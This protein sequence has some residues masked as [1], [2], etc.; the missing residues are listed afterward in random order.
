MELLANSANDTYISVTESLVMDMNGNRVNPV[1]MGV[2]NAEQYVRDATPPNLVSVRIDLEV[3]ELFLTFDEPVKINTTFVERVTLQSQK[4]LTDSG[5]SLT[6]RGGT[7][8]YE[9]NTI[10]KTQVMITILPTDIRLIKLDAQL[11]IENE[12]SAFVSVMRGMIRDMAMNEV[13]PISSNSSL[14]FDLVEYDGVR[15]ILLSFDID[16]DA[17]TLTL[18]FDDVVSTTGTT[19]RAQE[20]TL[21]SSSVLSDSTSYRLTGGTT[22]S[23]SGYVVVVNIT[24]VDLNAIKKNEG[25][26][27]GRNATYL[28]HTSGM[29]TDERGLKVIVR[30]PDDGLQVTELTED[31]TDPQLAFYDMDMDVGIIY[32]S[33]S[34]TVKAS[35]LNRTLLTL[36]SVESTVGYA[37]NGSVGIS[38]TLTGGYH[39]LDDLTTI[40]VTLSKEDRDE[41]K[42]LFG[43]SISV[44]STFLSFPF[45]LIRDMNYNDIVPHSMDSAQMART[46]V[47]DLTRPRLVFWDLDV[48][49]GNLSMLLDETVDASTFVVT[50]LRIQGSANSSDIFTLTGGNSTVQDGTYISVLLTFEDL[51]EV[52]KID[53]IGTSRNDSFLS[54][55]WTLVAD[56]NGNVISEVENGKAQQAR[57]HIPDR[58]APLLWYYDLDVDE[59]MMLLTFSE[60]V[61][62]RTVRYSYFSLQSSSS[63]NSSEAALSLTGGTRSQLNSR[64]LN[65]TFSKQDRDELTR[66]HLLAVSKNSSYL[67]IEQNAIEDMNGNYIQQQLPLLPVV[68]VEDKTEPRLVFVDLDL[69]DGKLILTFD[70]TVNAA[71]FLITDLILQSS[72]NASSS[73]VLQSRRLRDSVSSRRDSVSIEV[74]LYPEDLNEIK[75]SKTLAISLNST[76]VVFTDLLVRDMNRNKVVAVNNR[77]AFAAGN[78][79]EDS[80]SP[81]L[82]S[83]TVNISASQLSLTFSETVNVGSFVSSAFTFLHVSNASRTSQLEKSFT[84]TS[85]T[86]SRSP[87]GVTMTVDISREDL[88]EIKRIR[89]LLVSDNTTFLSVTSAGIKDMNENQVKSIPPESALQVTQFLPDTIRPFLD[90][91]DLDLDEGTLVL[92]FSETVDATSLVIGA[93]TLQHVVSAVVTQDSYTLV[94]GVGLLYSSSSSNDSTVITIE[95]GISDLNSLKRVRS[96]AQSEESTYLV[97]SDLLIR[98]MVGLAVVPRSNLSALQ[99][100]NYTSDVTGP[101]LLEF[102][103]NLTSEYL[104]LT[105][106]ET[107]AGITLN[108]SQLIIQSDANATTWYRLTGFRN[109]TRDDNHVIEIKLALDD[110]HAIKLRR[111]LAISLESSWLRILSGAVE[112]TALTPNLNELATLQSSSFVPDFVKPTVESYTVDMNSGLLTFNFDEPMDPSTLDATSL[113]LQTS[114]LSSYLPRVYRLTGGTSPSGD[115]LQLLLYLSDDDLNEIKRKEELFINSE[116]SYLVVDSDFIKDMSG[117][118]IAKI[119][120]GYA[121][122][123]S[124]YANDTN[125]A[126]LIGVE[127][128]MNS[129]TVTLTFDETMDLSSLQFDQFTLQ[130][131]SNV[132]SDEERVTL[133][134][135]MILTI[136]D[137][138]VFS[139]RLSYFDLNQVKSKQIAD[140]ASR[141]WFVY[142]SRFVHDMNRVSAVAR[143]NGVNAAN[144]SRHV[145]DKTRPRLHDFRISLSNGTLTLQFSEAIDMSAVDVTGLLLQFDNFIDLK[146]TQYYY[147]LTESSSTSSSS[148][149]PDVVTVHFSD[150]DLDA[151]KERTEL[152]ISNETTYISMVSSTFQDTVEN[153]VVAISNRLAMKTSDFEADHVKPQ[154]LSFDLDLTKEELV[155]S[156]SE[157]VDRASLNLT[158]LTISSGRTA[159]EFSGS[160]SGSGSGST[161]D[162]HSYT[163]TGGDTSGSNSRTLVIYLSEIDLNAIKKDYE[164]AVNNKTTFISFYSGLILDLNANRIDGITAADAN[165][166]TNYVKDSV[167][168]SLKSYTLDLNG[169]S[170]SLT[171]DETVNQNTLNVTQISFQDRPSVVNT[172][173]TLTGGVSLSDNETVIDVTLSEDDLNEIKRLT[174]LAT[175]VGNTFV[176]MQG[177]AIRDMAGNPVVER[178]D[179]SALAVSLFTSD[180]TR[181]RLVAYSLDMNLGS[182]VL[183]FRETVDVSSLDLTKISLQSTMS[184]TLMEG[185]QYTLTGGSIVSTRDGTSVAAKLSFEDLNAIKRIPEIASSETST[186]L[187]HDLGVIRD[188]S[189]NEAAA[190]L[191]GSALKVSQ[192]YYDTTSPTLDSFTMEMDSGVML[193]TF[194]E[195]VN[196]TT[197][198]LSKFEFQDCADEPISSSGSDSGSSMETGV[199]PYRLSGGGH[200]DPEERIRFTCVLPDFDLNEIKRLPICTNSRKG[201]DCY[202]TFDGSLI[203]DMAGNEIESVFQGCGFPATLL[204][205][206]LTS[207]KL[208]TFSEFNLNV[209]TISLLFDETLNVSTVNLTELRL[210][211]FIRSA[212]HTFQLTGGL[213]TS[214]DGPMLNITLLKE[215]V[216]EIKVMPYVCS[217]ENNCWLSFTSDFVKDMAMNPAAEVTVSAAV[218]S[219]RFVDDE[220]SPTL[221]DYHLDLD[222]GT[223]TLSFD[224]PV[225]TSSLDARAITIQNRQFV[226]KSFDYV[227]LTGGRS[228]SINGAVI[229]VTLLEK[230]VNAIKARSSLASSPNDTYVRFTGDLISDM[231]RRRPNNVDPQT[232]GEALAAEEDSYTGDVT[233]PKLSSFD[234]DLDD[235][236]LTLS[237]DEPLRISTLNISNFQLLSSNETEA[238][239]RRLTGGIVDEATYSNGT[240]HVL[241]HLYSSDIR[242]L[243]INTSIATERG[244]TR[245]A[246]FPQTIQDMADN[247]ASP[248]GRSSSIQVS[249]FIADQTA[250]TLTRYVLDLN[251][252][253]LRLTFNDV[254]D[255]KSLFGP[256]FTLQTGESRNRNYVSLTSNST[257]ASDSGYDIVLQLSESDLNAVK[258]NVDLGTNREDTYLA[259]TAQAVDDVFGVDVIAVTDHHALRASEVIEDQTSPLLRRFSLDMD[260]GLLDLTFSETIRSD[261]FNSTDIVLVSSSIAENASV[262]R[263][264]TNASTL[265]HSPVLTFILSTADVNELK[266]LNSLAVSKESTFLSHSLQL[267]EDMNGN[268]VDAIRNDAAQQV[269][270]F[271]ADTTSPVLQGFSLNMTSEEMSLTFDETVNGSTLTPE[272]IIMVSPDGSFAYH[273]TGG[274]PVRLSSTVSTLRL[275]TSDLN[276]LKSF[277]AIAVSELTTF[278]LLNKGAIEDMAGND[279]MSLALDSRI[280]AATFYPDTVRPRLLSF[281]LNMNTGQMSLVFDET[282]QPTSTTLRYLVLQTSA[283]GISEGS[284]RLTG[285]LATSQLSTV[286]NVTLSDPDLNILKQVK[287]IA[288]SSSD[289]YL[290]VDAGMIDDV[291]ANPVQAIPTYQAMAVSQYV[292]DTNRPFVSAFVL[293]MNRGVVTMTFSETVLFSSVLPSE[294]TLLG[295]PNADTKNA[296]S[297]VDG[298]V[299][300]SAPIDN[301]LVG[302]NPWVDANDSVTVDVFLTLDDL[303]DL[304]RIESLATNISNTY[305]AIES[306]FALDM[307]GNVVEEISQL[308]PLQASDLIS[309]YTPPRLLSFELDMNASRLTLS[310]S[311]TVDVSYLQITSISL[312]D[313]RNWTVS[314]TFSNVSR[315]ISGDGPD[316]VIDLH[317]RDTNELKRVTG[318]STNGNNT[319]LSIGEDAVRDMSNNS[320]VPIS[321]SNALQVKLFTPDD[322]QP[323][324]ESFS[325]DMDTGQLLLTFSET[326]NSSS[327]V[328]DRLQLQSSEDLDNATQFY[329]LTSVSGTKTT[330]VDGTILQVAISR[331]DS[332]AIKR[333]RQLATLQNN[334]FLSVIMGAVKDMNDLDLVPVLVS[335][336]APVEEYFVDVS[337]PELDAFS[338]NLTSEILVLTFDETVDVVSLDLSKFDLV[339][340]LRPTFFVN[341]TGGDKLSQEDTHVVSVKL[342]SSDLN[343]IKLDMMLATSGENTWLVMEGYAVKDVAFDQNGA[344]ATILQASDFGED[345]VSPRVTSFEVDMNDGTIGLVFNEPVDANSFMYQQLTLQASVSSGVYVTLSGGSSNSANGLRYTVHISRDDLNEVKRLTELFT[346]R[347]SSYISF[348]S[349]LVRDIAGNSVTSVLNQT[350]LQTSAFHND[351]I[352]PRIVNFDLDMNTGHVTLYFLET[353]D[354]S[355]LDFEGVTLQKALNVSRDNERQTLTNG[356]LLNV[357]DSVALRF[358]LTVDDLNEIKRKEIAR[359]NSTCYLVVADGAVIDMNSQPVKP[360]ENGLSSLPVSHYTPD[361]TPPRLQSYSLNLTSRVLSLSFTETVRS[362]AVMTTGL[363]MQSR[364][365]ASLHAQSHV[366]SN[367]SYVQSGDNAV[368]SIRLEFLDFNAIKRFTNLAVSKET[369]YLSIAA[370]SV[371]DMVGNLIAKVGVSRGLPAT[372]FTPDIVRPLLNSYTLDMDAPSL[373]LSFSETVNISSLL[374]LHFTIQQNASGLEMSSYHLTG[375]TILGGNDAVV[376]V[377][378]SS[379]DFN[380]IKKRTSLAVDISSTHLSLTSRS[381][382]D[383]DGNRILEI[384]AVEALRARSYIKDETPPQITAFELDMNEGVITLNFSETVNTTSVRLSLLSIRN[385]DSNATSRHTLTD[386]EVEARGTGMQSTFGPSLKV[387]ISEFDLND[388]KAIENLAVRVNDTFLTANSLFVEDMDDN[389]LVSVTA[390]NALKV[391]V[392]TDDVTSPTLRSFDVNMTT[393]VLILRFSETVNAS[394]LELTEVSLQNAKSASKSTSFYQ[395]T[396]GAISFSDN[397]VIGVVLSDADSN[398]IKSRTTLFTSVNN[399]YVSLSENTIRD[400]RR[401]SVVSISNGS[402]LRV[403]SFAA[404]LIRPTLNDFDLNMT[405]EQL[406][407][408]FSESVA[409]VSLD[410]T[411]ITLQGVGNETEYSLKGG[412]ILNS[413]NGTTVIIQ[414][415]RLDANNIQALIGLGDSTNTTFLSLT[416]TAVLDMNLNLVVAAN[417][418]SVRSYTEDTVRP[419]LNFWDIN[420]NLGTIALFFSETVNTFSLDVGKWDLQSNN[421]ESSV[422]HRFDRSRGTQTTSSN[423]SNVVLEIGTDDLNE[424]KKLPALGTSINNTYISFSELAVLDMNNNRIVPV[425]RGDALQVRKFTADVTRPIL[426]NFVLDMNDGTLSLTFSETINASSFFATSMKLQSVNDSDEISVI[427]SGRQQSL[428]DDYIVNL[429]LSENTLN[430]IKRMS[431][432]ATML[433][434]TFLSLSNE[435]VEDMNGNAIVAIS[436]ENATAAAMYYSDIIAPSLRSFTLDLNEGLLV[437]SFSETVNSSSLSIDELV[438]HNFAVGTA[439]F[440]QYRLTALSKVLPFDESDSHV[441]SLPLSATDLNELKRLS[442]LSSKLDGS[443]TF[444]AFNSGFVIDMNGNEIEASSVS[445]GTKVSMI[446]AD[447][448]CPTLA[449][450]SLDMNYGMIRLTF[451]ETVNSSSLNAGFVRIQGTAA[452]NPAF[453]HVFTSTDTDSPDGTILELSV[454]DEDLNQIKILPIVA[455]S[456]ENSWIYLKQDA[457]TDMSGNGYCNDTRP[458]Q[459]T[460]GNFTADSKAP[461]LDSYSVDMD[462]GLIT[463]TFSEAV[464]RTDVTKLT[465]HGSSIGEGNITLTG[466]LPKVIEVNETAPEVVQF[467]LTEIDLNTLKAAELIATGSNDTYLSFPKSAFSDL[468]GNVMYINA[469]APRAVA[470]YV[471]DS[472]PPLLTSFN[473]DMNE[474]LLIMSFS[475]TVNVTSV[476]VSNIFL[477]NDTS[478]ILPIAA[479][480]LENALVSQPAN[481][482]I[483]FELSQEDV[484]EIKR[485]T[486]L[487]Y[488]DTSTYLY[489]RSSTLRD[490]V[491]LSVSSVD[492]IA[493]AKVAVYEYDKT[494]PRLIS[495]SV[496]LTSETISLSFDETVEGSSLN[497][498]KISLMSGLDDGDKYTLRGGTVITEDSTIVVVQLE[499]RDLN[500]IKLNENLA[501]SLNNT[502]LSVDADYVNDLSSPPQSSEAIVICASEYGEDTVLPRLTTFALDIN[503][504]ILTLNFDEPVRRSSVDFTQLALQAMKSV[505]SSMPNLQ[506]RLAGGFSV[507]TN[508]LILKINITKDDL[509]E[510]KRKSSLATNNANTYIRVGSG[511]LEDMNNNSIIAILESSAVRVSNFVGDTGRPTLVSFDLDMDSSLLT[512]YFDETVDVSSLRV[513]AMDLQS[514]SRVDVMADRVSL[515]GMLNRT[516]DDTIV[517]ILLSLDTM[518]ELKTKRV[519]TNNSSSWL[520]LSDVTIK[521]MAGELVAPLVNGVNVESVTRYTTDTTQP[522]L[523]DFSIDLTLETILLTFTETVDARTLDSTF[524]TL[525]DGSSP[526]TADAIISFSNASIVNENSDDGPIVTLDIGAADLNRLKEITKLGTSMN[527]TFMSLSKGGVRDVFGND[528]EEASDVQVDKF[529]GDDTR[530]ELSGFD[531]DLD[532]GVMSVTF[533]ETVRAASLDTSGI[534]I[535]SSSNLTG[536]RYDSYTLSGLH[537]KVSEDSTVLH[538]DLTTEDLNNL[539]FKRG[540]ATSRDSTYIS[541]DAKAIDDMYGNELSV[542]NRVSALIANSYV[543]DTT[544]P[545]LSD[546]SLDMNA[547]ELTISFDE[548]VKN[549]SLVLPKLSVRDNSTYVSFEY[550]LTG[551]MSLS[552]DSSQ[553][554]IEL[555]EADLNEIKRLDLCSHFQNGRDC[556]IVLEEAAVEDMAGNFVKGC[557]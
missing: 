548:T 552:H 253:E 206:D 68:F 332:N 470:S 379:Y 541:V 370:G 430:E 164:L 221:L 43:L 108:V 110:L 169:E 501:T 426:H 59:G 496:N 261:S 249:D 246:M 433:G 429:N 411:Q 405:S 422:L 204:E 72:F 471:P 178:V 348:T 392:F 196:I 142:S 498:P 52:K 271:T 372:Q 484:N 289:T 553:L 122:Q 115:G 95:I 424:I 506:Q 119:S 380:E 85:S 145:M 481:G 303:N 554:N 509:D 245:I 532:S 87:D 64:F 259:M 223:L 516:V 390:D 525:T 9:R 330:S 231:V 514:D 173:Y 183:N 263:L 542:I 90:G 212:E 459:V 417:R 387:S 399:S 428:D 520:S 363:T 317:A 339:N 482:I 188:M 23:P 310:F 126:R 442:K 388:I 42:R 114:P 18:T 14:V 268:S 35:S 512:L 78:Y 189:S 466:S 336:A 495:F 277:P 27:T 282:V 494:R 515:T 216:D 407:L 524:I 499:K 86:L 76:F 449:A 11:I 224:E 157:I 8:E 351:T 337:E 182:M 328:L 414:L 406:S 174:G 10:D 415:T 497:V 227:K 438:I 107:V 203:Q 358:A 116:T 111:S 490:M 22:L 556:Y 202:V 329:V 226:T 62:A 53:E 181:P 2:I 526:P 219:K 467:Y 368:I 205:P 21:Q 198:Q 557:R 346:S 320:L 475:E 322:I 460:A 333:L 295:R 236:V 386:G 109:H 285:G 450:F 479:Y 443:D 137:S 287:N 313:S 291:A 66:L 55:N 138:T 84:L 179:G 207:P 195:A 92:T 508:G 176:T 464:H 385:K 521:D 146:R 375:G 522:R 440:Q 197:L 472:T 511:F 318:I 480:R 73:Y 321:S 242:F 463:L 373:T 130:S 367:S 133:S 284:V 531:L 132:T 229:A 306:A 272:R 40:N 528:V 324:L 409:A 260:R 30:K 400:M 274:S 338:L 362:D 28:T 112:D 540:L 213:V 312:L 144:V 172:S 50:E 292:N 267:V 129:G 38:F 135:G 208:L 166:V 104:I 60:T 427:L 36:Q 527:N 171:F 389:P 162:V 101:S 394:S 538:I 398:A 191:D 299:S 140:V 91:Y 307:R 217:D 210:Q 412:E 100:R 366:I 483:H 396:G 37:G 550:M 232:N 117:N 139:F 257:T 151:I 505:N 47:P 34:E 243:K 478:S 359:S 154:L 175:G 237:F 118:N 421:S 413:E 544:S 161:P 402:A 465:F 7:Y 17:S 74:L 503:S 200:C 545:V 6:L 446:T 194:S 453:L 150:K 462:S 507:S 94:G 533:S 124:N 356:S 350:A 256:A 529:T 128:D 301:G 12:D 420:L 79:T 473:L 89:G 410:P 361:I 535:A 546:W 247:W 477:Q 168:P 266:R 492:S 1:E 54:F 425:S 343:D 391:S 447:L 106:D 416:S 81:E 99:V 163:L 431:E 311:E 134:N 220:K 308:S 297:L 228:S 264:Q 395:L 314:H 281:N 58:T 523:V 244:D 435:T 326:V 309:D 185:L 349:L 357:D 476:V 423:T 432:L 77:T 218:E 513:N 152:A 149:S 241:I 250:A 518:N 485:M 347:N 543:S 186:Y 239:A 342:F 80:T 408:H 355:S 300:V 454:T 519:G 214:Q 192:Y 160:G 474:G 458:T 148:L 3:D 88:D 469:T 293:D 536:P 374:L 240:M 334:T 20:I 211:S 500:K 32:L 190:I 69:D 31:K 199:S 419:R 437:L 222:K 439:D 13:N 504:G 4:F 97:V 46:F 325:L 445:D 177:S 517:F 252:G 120:N 103:L 489:M 457:V 377:E 323:E 551:G 233:L 70:E 75:R 510:I 48:E 316:V 131:S 530:P 147:I 319:F 397:E 180:K 290:A 5:S 143:V 298:T 170:L 49:A 376:V 364:A 335:N 201:R 555:S 354:V 65:L 102:S 401:N 82:V 502:C 294:M 251:R 384:A 215:D 280:Q 187:V 61:R 344:S 534:T 63:T 302:L 371:S 255:A 234:L 487:A 403:A 276:Y 153:D 381:V 331:A 269:A 393:R 273:L 156:F 41:V 455:T 24:D 278:L 304:K 93:L 235:D 436:R 158:V 258:A 404:D 305:L 270:R 461:F 279:V 83:Y 56:M 248:L 15:P 275:S 345:T 383:M 141:S 365:N 33:F 491:G 113:V 105:F 327:L 123:A 193:L 57:R 155:L 547:G 127:L 340:N 98:D 238:V 283:N 71:S 165:S 26:S 45:S 51:N 488:S 493:A 434:N 19:L 418:L 288:T 136:N 369:T 44:N 468:V 16:L 451:D 265:N 225:L 378:M 262:Y 96:L 184:L 39:T 209:G 352:K 230:D 539:K 382:S 25:L 444:L 67:V 159:E 341:L 452:L 121:L 353:I 360:L 456:V 254:I 549:S 286:V 441:L 537:D 125:G 448:T 167:R 486:D 296:V 315:S 29:I